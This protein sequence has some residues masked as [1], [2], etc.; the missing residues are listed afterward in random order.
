MYLAFNVIINLLALVRGVYICLVACLLP[1]G[2]IGNVDADAGYGATTTNGLLLTDFA[3]VDFAERPPAG[4]PPPPA[5][6][7]AA[8]P[9]PV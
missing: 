9:A 5:A 1:P 2:K 3:G 6:A 8:K 4:R 7:A